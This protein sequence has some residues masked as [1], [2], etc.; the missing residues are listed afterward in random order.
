MPCCL[1]GVPIVAKRKPG[2]G[3]I[4]EKN[5]SL[6]IGYRPARGAKQIWEKVGRIDEG[7]TRADAEALLEERRVDARKGRLPRTIITLKELAE[8]WMEEREF[9]DLAPKTREAEATALRCHLLPAFGLDRIHEITPDLLRRYIKKKLTFAP[10]HAK[11]A[12]VV[13]KVASARKAPLGRTAVRQ[14]IQ[15]LNKIYKWAVEQGLVSSNPCDRVGKSALAPV[16]SEVQVFEI[17]EVRALLGAAEDDEERAIL[18]LMVGSGL[19]IGELFGLKI[20]DYEPANRRLYLQRTVQRDGGRTQLGNTAKT[21]SGDRYLVLDEPLA[22]AV[23]G[24]IDLVRRQERDKNDLLFPN[25]AGRIQSDTNF[26]N[27]NWKRLLKDAGLPPGRTPH[28]LRHTFASELIEAGNSDTD[29][30]S[31]MGHKNAQITRVVYAKTFERK[32]ATPAGVVGL[33]L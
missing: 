4:K 11:A 3:T 18:L 23:E 28:A 30:A 29:I 10:G 9:V 21:Q 22:E 19:R 26:R 25:A 16:A 32:K 1:G 15:T 24:Q 5:G 33:Y 31:K 14:Q 7:T 17:E 6:F 13:G 20:A 27:R 2:F 12:P 8:M